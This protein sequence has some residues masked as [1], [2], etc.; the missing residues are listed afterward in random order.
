MKTMRFRI[1]KRLYDHW[2][3]EDFTHDYCEWD[4]LPGKGQWLDRADAILDELREPDERMAS[5]GDSV[6]PDIEGDS[7]SYARASWR[8]MIDRA[9]D[10]GSHSKS[11]ESEDSEAG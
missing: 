10:N 8:A 4:A 3:K 7:T 5:A 6:M 1:A 2:R 9:R 11:E